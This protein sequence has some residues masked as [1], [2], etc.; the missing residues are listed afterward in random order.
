MRSLTSLKATTWQLRW[1]LFATV[2]LAIVGIAVRTRISAQNAE[3]LPPGGAEDLRFD[4]PATASN[5]NS[6]T[7]GAPAPEVDN[8]IDMS[9]PD[10]SKPPRKGATFD[11]EGSD[12][13][14]PAADDDTTKLQPSRNPQAPPNFDQGYE[15]TASVTVQYISEPLLAFEE[16]GIIRK[17]PKE[18]TK[19]Q[20]G[21][22]IASLDP[23]EMEL[24]VAI[25]E[26]T[27]K[28]AQYV[29]A[30][31][32]KVRYAEA[33]AAASK[34]DYE[35]GKEANKRKSNVVPEMEM[36]RRELEAEAG[37]LSI[38]N[39]RYEVESARL[40]SLVK[41]AELNAAKF[42]LKRMNIVS[43]ISGIVIKREAHDGQFVRAGDPV[44]K[45]AQLDRLR[46]SGMVPIEDISP[47]DILG[48]A[49]TI[50][51][52]CGRDPRTRKH[53]EFVTEATIEYVDADIKSNDSYQVWAEFD[54]TE[55]FVVRKGMTVKMIIH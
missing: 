5:P 16:S 24:K 13:E 23:K 8:D 44:L 27:L 55:D 34:A 6:G 40:T 1:L 54:N 31:K 41:E 2:V 9:L 45:I 32:I 4:E 17:I 39:A 20:A 12:Q 30:N 29:A 35:S 7:E 22:I 15:V 52:D 26:A 3:P 53:R 19:I 36:R 50:R 37:V 21:E 42:A 38:E 48:R 10:S 25:S 28:E 49:V 33:S 11:S 46:V 14:I 51:I 47:K 18:G 43:P